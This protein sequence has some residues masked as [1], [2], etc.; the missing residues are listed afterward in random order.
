M[1]EAALE[2]ERRNLDLRKKQDALGKAQAL[3]PRGKTQLFGLLGKALPLDLREALLL[4]FGEALA[5][6][7]SEA[8]TLGLGKA[9]AFG[10]CSALALSLG[11]AQAFGLCG[12][13]LALDLREALT[14]GFSKA[15]PLGFGA[16]VAL[17]LGDALA[18]C[19]SINILPCPLE[20]CAVAHVTHG[21]ESP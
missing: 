21:A 8:L 20:A 15:L 3:G 16:L 17:G 5:L 19:R 4:G 14:L 11:E 13:A 12:E 18:L 9:L 2:L 6:G 10:F 1:G 7:L